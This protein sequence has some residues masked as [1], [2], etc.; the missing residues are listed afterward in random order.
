MAEMAEMAA[1]VD[2]TL[3]AILLP[4]SVTETSAGRIVVP[5]HRIPEKTVRIDLEVLQQ[6]LVAA[7]Q[8]ARQAYAPY[9]NFHVGAAVLMADD[10][11]QRMITGANVENSSYGATI[12]GE[13]SAL[14]RAVGLGFRKLRYLA[15]S[16]ADALSSPLCDRSPC[17]TC[18]Q[19]VREFV[20]RA[21]GAPEAL[22]IVDTA[23][24]GSLCEVFDIERLLPYGFSFSPP[25]AAR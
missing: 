1:M 12:C 22:V 25:A 3:P 11:E 5:G 2:V 14:A 24:P 21:D 23:R 4:D 16:T 8:A 6:L 17:G 7:R 18:R 19:A 13:R 15:L 9:S 10:P 20:A